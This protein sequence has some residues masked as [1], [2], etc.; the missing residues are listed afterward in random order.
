MK[1]LLAILAL[2]ITFSTVWA[3]ETGLFTY[4]G[5]FF[6][7][8]GK[9]WKEYRPKD[10]PGVW[11]TYTQYDDETH[12]YNIT[13]SNCS[14]AIP[15]ASHNNFYKNENGKWVVIYTT[16]MVYP[17]FLDTSVKLY[18]FDKGYYVRD[19]KK[20]RLYLSERPSSV[21]ASFTQYD[22][23]KDYFYLTN[24]NDKVCVPKR[25]ELSCYLW[26]KT[27]KKWEANY[28]ITEIYDHI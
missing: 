2:A 26:N 20:W 5:G 10:R 11:A 23:D 18:C 15:K 21:W 22:E 14:L 17:S 24:S 3:A 1:R 13:N 19:G 8:N 7:K 6:I 16:R 4:Q 27:A 25:A 12:Y 28:D 9:T